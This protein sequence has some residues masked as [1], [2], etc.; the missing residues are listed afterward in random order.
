MLVYEFCRQ[1]SADFQLQSL[2]NRRAS[3]VDHAALLQA[4]LVR[5][6]PRHEIDFFGRAF[7]MTIAL[8]TMNLTPADPDRPVAYFSPARR[9]RHD[10]R[11]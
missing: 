9:L 2:T 7:L 8:T 6:I 11:K 1:K 5:Q 10:R 3:P 4:Q